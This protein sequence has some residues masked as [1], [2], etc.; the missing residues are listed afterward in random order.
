M[1]KRTRSAV[2]PRVAAL[3]KELQAD[4]Y[5]KQSTF[6][7][8]AGRDVQTNLTTGQRKLLGSTIA[9]MTK[10]GHRKRHP[11][12]ALSQYAGLAKTNLTPKTRYEQL[13]QETHERVQLPDIVKKSRN[14]YSVNQVGLVETATQNFAKS[15]QKLSAMIPIGM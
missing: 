10:Q 12:N 5:Q 13:M 9:F 7:V 1:N 4:G 15:K 3:E 2:N 11:I 8:D 14:E 6:T